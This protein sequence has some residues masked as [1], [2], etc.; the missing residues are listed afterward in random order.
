MLLA[1][2]GEQAAREY[3]VGLGYQIIGQNVRVGAWEIDLIAETNQ[4]IVFIEVKTTG[5]GYR[6]EDRLRVT[7][8]KRLFQAAERWLIIRRLENRV[9]RFDL[10]VVEFN[11]QTGDRRIEHHEDALRRDDTRVS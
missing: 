5:A 10:L 7:Q 2:D 11:S 1:K 4:E 3:L 8:Q 9:A 6:P